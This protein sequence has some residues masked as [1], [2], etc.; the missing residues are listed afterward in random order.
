MP[1]LQWRSTAEDEILIQKTLFDAPDDVFDR[2]VRRETVSFEELVSRRLVGETDGP[3]PVDQ[4][5]R[6]KELVYDAL[7]KGSGGGKPG[8]ELTGLFFFG[9]LQV[10]D[11]HVQENEAVEDLRKKV[12]VPERD[13]VEGDRV[14]LAEHEITEDMNAALQR[15]DIREFH[16]R[17]CPTGRT[18]RR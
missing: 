1:F 11:L 6:V 8:V 10:V 12:Q 2:L 7:E 4:E 3:V 17:G 15:V 18:V 16:N 9:C 13:L 14:P 5:E